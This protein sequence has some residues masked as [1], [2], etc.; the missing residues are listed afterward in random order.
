MTGLEK[1]EGWFGSG[2]LVAP[3]AGE[4]SFVDL[5]RGLARLGGV[6]V[7][8]DGDGVR[9][10][11]EHLLGAESEPDHLV[12]VVVD[13][14]GYRTLERMAPA[15][16]F[17]RSHLRA[18]MQAV[19]P[20]TTAAALATLATAQWPGIHSVSTWWIYDPQRELTFA[21][22]LFIERTSKRP[23]EDLGL[24]AADLFPLPSIW[25]GTSSAS[26]LFVAPAEQIGST[27]TRYLSGG[28]PQAGYLSLS[29]A[30]DLVVDHVSSAGAPTITFLYL[31][32]LDSLC[33][34]EGTET[35]GVAR[36]LAA[37]D[38]QI[39]WIHERLPRR[40]RLVISADHGLANVPEHRNLVLEA[41]H[42]LFETLCCPPSGEPNIPI[43]HVRPGEE[44]RFLELMQHE[45]EA[46]FALI[47]PDEAQ[48]LHLFGPGEIAPLQRERLGTFLGIAGEPTVLQ[49]RLPGIVPSHF[50]GIH[51]GLTAEE[52]EIPLIV[53]AT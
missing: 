18:R 1:I 26:L 7:P 28:Q 16:G 35:E 5:V 21:S 27:F 14:L 29:D 24:E 17:L 15:R 38:V 22:L 32:H 25:G 46:D 45:V 2:R 53:A 10:I 41:G 49:Y 42:P 13:G 23:L 4:L 31:P 52:I 11:C 50:V 48:G 19:F 39:A 30:A 3:S 6:A 36:L 44:G 9:Q 43:F 37:L 20:P 34:A 47:T 40:T 12:F 33:H 8:G 51:A